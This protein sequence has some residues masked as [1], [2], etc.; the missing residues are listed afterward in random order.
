MASPFPGM[1]PYVEARVAWPDVRQRL[2]INFSE[3]L[4]PH[5]RPHY[6]ACIGERV[7]LTGIS[8]H[9]EVAWLNGQL[10]EIGLHPA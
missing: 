2:I 4:Q 5:L 6:I 9:S 1:D 7:Q 3:N 10:A 8:R